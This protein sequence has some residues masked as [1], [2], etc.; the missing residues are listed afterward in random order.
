[1]SR[2]GEFHAGAVVRMPLA[3]DAAGP[4]SLKDVVETKPREEWETREV[5]VDKLRATQS[6]LSPDTVSRIAAT[7]KSKMDTRKK[8]PA[9]YEHP[10][11]SVWVGDGHHRLAAAMTRGD[12]TAR[13][14]IKGT[15]AKK[16]QNWPAGARHAP[17]LVD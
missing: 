12:A 1:M 4:G 3:I 10:D 6:R 11:G 13:V 8:M 2:T 16:F 7:P 14:T 9:G 17:N 5:P 15:V